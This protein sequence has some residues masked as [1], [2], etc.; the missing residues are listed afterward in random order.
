MPIRRISVVTCRRPTRAPGSSAL[1]SAYRSV[2]RPTSDAARQ[3]LIRF[4]SCS[5]KPRA[6]SKR[7]AAQI[8]QLCLALHRHLTVPPSSL[9]AQAGDFPSAPSKNHSPWSDARS[10]CSSRIRSFA[11]AATHPRRRSPQR[12]PAAR[13]SSRQPWVRVDL[14]GAACPRRLTPDRLQGHS[15]LE[16]RRVVSSGSS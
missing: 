2:E 12:S 10:V 14:C 3:I 16:C 13:S 9:A 5:G 1:G 4:R 15:C 11:S 8:Q 6:T 7:R